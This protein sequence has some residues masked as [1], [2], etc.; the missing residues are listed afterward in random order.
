MTGDLTSFSTEFH[1]YQDNGRKMMKGCV[2]KIPFKVKKISS[3]AGLGPGTARSIG[4]HLAHLAT[5]DT[6]TKHTKVH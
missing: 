6:V 3:W 4:Q 5:G 1:S 2:N